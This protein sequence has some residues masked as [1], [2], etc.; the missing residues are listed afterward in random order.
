[1]TVVKQWLARLRNRPI[2]I[3][4]VVVS[5]YTLIQLLIQGHNIP[6][7]G[8]VCP[9]YYTSLPYSSS[10]SVQLVLLKCE[11]YYFPVLCADVL[12]LLCVINEG[13]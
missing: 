8:K 13:V 3:Y 4:V 11:L 10:V 7:I 5:L 12:L 1:M 9:V 2:Q 6:N